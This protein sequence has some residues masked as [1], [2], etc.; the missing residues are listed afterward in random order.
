MQGRVAGCWDW[1]AEVALGEWVQ[2]EA[3]VGLGRV[4]TTTWPV[5]SVACLAPWLPERTLSD[6][7]QPWRGDKTQSSP[8]LGSCTGFFC[9]G[10]AKPLCPRFLPHLCLTQGKTPLQS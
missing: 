6:F 7:L 4:R 3:R 8:G 5:V 10:L 1:R 2:W 9:S